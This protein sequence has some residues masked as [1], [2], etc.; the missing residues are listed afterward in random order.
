MSMRVE[1]G[2]AY[3]ALG[4]AVAESMKIYMDTA[5]SLKDVRCA[6]PGDFTTRQLILDADILG[7]IVV[8]ALGGGGALL[9]RRWYPLLLSAAGLMLLSAYYRSVL[10]SPHPASFQ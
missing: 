8:L 5:P 4:V 2:V 9:V 3:A 6:P 10:A 1:E 7:F